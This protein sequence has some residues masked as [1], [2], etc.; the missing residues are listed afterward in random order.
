LQRRCTIDGYIDGACSVGNVVDFKLVSTSGCSGD[1]VEGDR[2]GETGAEAADIGATG[3][4][5]A[6]VEACGNSELRAFGL[7]GDEGGRGFVAVA[8]NDYTV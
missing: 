7:V 8:R 6:V 2:I 4:A 5:G 1:V 3:G